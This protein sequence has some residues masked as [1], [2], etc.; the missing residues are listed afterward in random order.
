MASVNRISIYADRIMTEIR[1]DIASTQV[2]VTVASFS[3]LHD[4]VDANCYLIDYVPG[5]L[6]APESAEYGTTY[7]AAYETWVNL[8]ND[9]ADEVDRRIKS[10]ELTRHGKTA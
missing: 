7:E 1:N 9:V 2:P 3:E 4:H 5:D 8:G 10:G 6:P